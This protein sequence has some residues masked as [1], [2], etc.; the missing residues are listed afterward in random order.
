MKRDE[1]AK[2]AAVLLA[3]SQ[4]ETIQWRPSPHDP[5]IDEKEP[6]FQFDRSYY[7]V[8][9]PRRTL[10]ALY[11]PDGIFAEAVDEQGI[12]SGDDGCSIVRFIEAEGEA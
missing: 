9:P 3:F 10:W 12:L 8:K 11:G 7:R 4:G 2:A 6:Q 1:A 5:W